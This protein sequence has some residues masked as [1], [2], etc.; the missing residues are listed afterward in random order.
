MIGQPEPDGGEQLVVVGAGPAGLAAAIF[1]ARAGARVVVY[2]RARVVGSRFH[3]DFQG[4]ENWTSEMDVLDELGGFG[5]APTFEHRGVHEQVCF[6]PGGRCRTFRS[7]RPF[8]YLVR[9]GPGHGTVDSSL[10]DQALAAGVEIRFGESVEHLPQGGIV[11]RGPRRADVI[12]V[13][14]IFDTDAPDGS[15]GVMDDQLAP[16][17]YAYLLIWGGRATIAACMFAD[18]HRERFHLERT[19]DFFRRNLG[20]RMERARRFGGMGSFTASRGLGVD[21]LRFAGEAA[22]L[23]DALWGFGMR[24]AMLSGV[25]AVPRPSPDTSGSLE[26]LSRRLKHL[27]AAG[28]VNRFLYSRIGNPGYSLVLRFMERAGDQR[29]WLR[30]RYAHSAW[31]A[32]VAPAAMALTDRGKARP[33]DRPGCDCTWCRCHRGAEPEAT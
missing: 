15:Y 14:Y 13:G 32:L 17:G 11:A 7:S 9:R 23:Q 8:Y 16:K 26:M 1:A 21:G 25:L 3:D 4:L 2:E 28:R 30:Q 19:V 22:G 10:R 12:A 6:G 24:Y 5:I 33:C 29:T 20:I 27:Y 18:F 31:K